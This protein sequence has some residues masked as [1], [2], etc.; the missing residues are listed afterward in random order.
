[1]KYYKAI[2]TIA[3]KYKR[4]ASDKYLSDYERQQVCFEF[5][6]WLNDQRDACDNHDVDSVSSV[7][8]EE[9]AAFCDVNDVDPKK[10]VHRKY[11]FDALSYDNEEDW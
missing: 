2:E 1:M 5:I 7:E 3:A 6:D 11:G 9:W 10:K 8:Q 4:L